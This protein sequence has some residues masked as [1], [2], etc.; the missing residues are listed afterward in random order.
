[1]SSADVL[2]STLQEL[3]TDFTSTF[4]QDL[5]FLRKVL[6]RSKRDTFKGPYREFGVVT[7]GPGS[8]KKVNYG[9]ELLQSGRRQNSSKGNVY[10]SRI[11][12][13]YAVPNLDLA[14]ISNAAVLA[15]IIQR[16]PAEGLQEIKQD[17]TAQILRGA[18]SAGTLATVSNANDL[19]GIMTFNGLQ[20]YT[21][22][23]T[24]GSRGGFF[25]FAAKASQS[26][27]VY[28]LTSEGSG[29]G[30]TG[31]YNE[32]ESIGSMF[33][34]GPRK[35]RKLIQRTS[36]NGLVGGKIDCL[37]SDEESMHNYVE[38][39]GEKVRTVVMKDDA[40]K[41]S[42]E[43]DTVMIQGA[44]WT[45]DE[46][47]DLSDTTAFSNAA[48]QS[49]VIY[50]LCSADWEILTH[51]ASSKETKGWFEFVDVGPHPDQDMHNFRIVMHFQPYCKQ[52]RRQFCATGGASI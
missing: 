7:G 16:Y 15:D 45:W 26:N 43:G 6:E 28:G 21:P 22:S 31:W 23:P 49:G 32:Y 4:V 42:G 41:F 40:V 13:H 33:S 51:G 19:D 35:L 1:M 29:S 38:A 25:E 24:A 9:D 17:V 36:R 8:Y 11:I 27:T 50:G 48:T 3:D 30:T 12:Y 47:I 34:D 37:L 46:S 52:R 10:A 18:A 39:E 44:E 2:N 14:E 5:P 20:S